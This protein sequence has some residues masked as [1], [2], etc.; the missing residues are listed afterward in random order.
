MS[1]PQSSSDLAALGADLRDD[2]DR[3]I[4]H[5]LAPTATLPPPHIDEDTLIA[6]FQRA[7]SSPLRA[8]MLRH[9]ARCALCC[10]RLEA[11]AD[12]L[13]V[14][15]LRAPVVANAPRAS[16]SPVL[17]DIGDALMHIHLQVGASGALRV[18]TTD[19]EMRL[20]PALLMRR[21]S[22]RPGLAFQKRLRD[23]TLQLALLSVSPSLLHAT[24]TLDPARAGHNV[25]LLAGGQVLASEPLRLGQASFRA[26][27][28]RALTLCLRGP[29]SHTLGHIRLDLDLAD[30]L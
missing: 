17:L 1:T 26:L 28:I 24:L 11:C 15:D 6:H 13:R 9:L 4:R 10:D 21:A 19:A 30:D 7:L 18:V 8:D 29:T 22:R 12:A 20:E 25:N 23:V 5:L 16:A 14:A 2:L 3:R 27:P